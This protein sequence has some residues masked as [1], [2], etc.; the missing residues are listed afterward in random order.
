[1]RRTRSAW[2]PAL[3]L[4]CCGCGCDLKCVD[5]MIEDGRTSE[6]EA[7]AREILSQ[8]EQRGDGAGLDAARA[9][10]RIVL[11]RFR[12]GKI[13]DPETLALARRS[14]ELWDAE[15]PADDPDRCDSLDQLG[16]LLNFAGD[17][18]RAIELHRRA[19]GLRERAFGPESLEVSWTLNYLAPLLWDIGDYVAARPLFER[20][21]AIRRAHGSGVDGVLNNLAGLAFEMGDYPTAR[22]LYEETLALRLARRPVHPLVPS[23][24]TNLG[25]V[26]HRLGELDEAARLALE[27]RDALEAEPL[28]DDSLAVTLGL[29]GDIELSRGR[30]AQAADYYRRTR[31]ELQA[32]VGE[33]H[34]HL[35]QPTLGLAEALRRLGKPDEA[36]EQVQRAMAIAAERLDPD[37]PLVAASAG[38]LARVLLDLGDIDAA[39]E[40]AL[41]A[42]SASRRHLR[43]TARVLAERQGLR[44]AATRVSGLDLALSLAVGGPKPAG[45]ESVLDAVIHSR[46]LVLDEMASRK[47]A[48]ARGAEDELARQLES[49]AAAR[50]RLA[51]LMVRGVSGDEP[52]RA[53][54]VEAARAEFER[55][56]QQLARSSEPY[57]RMLESGRV[58]L[59]DVRDALPR[60]GALVAIA[61]YRR[62]LAGEST[63]PV[64]SYAALVLRGGRAP[65]AVD[66][67]RADEIDTLIDG[68]RDEVALRSESAGGGLEAAEQAYRRVAGKVRERIWDPVAAAL[69][70]ADPVY[71][72]PDGALST[73]NL[74]TLPVG[75]RKYLV[76]SGP[77][78]HLLSAERDL[79][80]LRAERSVGHGLL[81][82]GNP[83]F[84]PREGA[85][86]A[87]G[88]VRAAC[89][90][91]GAEQFG[92]LPESEIEIDE[93]GKTWSRPG[94]PV[95]RVTGA[96]ATE[97]RFKADAPGKRVVHLAT[98]GFFLGS[99]CEPAPPGTRSTGLAG[100]DGADA[101][102]GISP[103]A[104]SGLVFAGANQ[105]AEA[106]ADQD[107]GVLTAEEITALDLDGVEWVVLSACDTALGEIQAGEGVLGLRR[108]F[109]LAG[110]RTLIMSL[111][112]VDDT[113]TRQW[114][115]RL[116]RAR[117]GGAS[118]I[119]AVRGA[120][121]SMLEAR[122]AA[123]ESTH[124]FF[125]GAFVATGGWT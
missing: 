35:V 47:H 104:L 6:A 30:P 124:P 46:A 109:R 55:A 42:E 25:F 62:H 9:L 103:L 87:A 71:V 4:F 112:S 43:I 74:S 115:A 110:A 11:A 34:P 80:A 113:A 89:G 73:V 16:V 63:E 76:E 31:A 118:T 7:R 88:T 117:L 97:A 54:Q 38:R 69:D 10:D 64:P 99:R 90:T 94:E 39:L 101:Q 77:R 32:I 122:R 49:L 68:W 72:V 102:A 70:G 52:R 59:A 41:E 67:G 44:Y 13:E 92:P 86:T 51:N 85:S 2:L 121:R 20:A 27:A 79:V 5:R 37:H 98:H 65:V 40:A 29:L 3:L 58:G 91:L 95:E 45:S 93:I 83:D 82:M 57:R 114:M 60:G 48:V 53:A 15:A 26:L 123:A 23:T 100:A 8:V 111:W 107:D 125:W 75:S 96:A 12:G 119:D 61:R 105:R 56:E 50:R 66:L 28:G 120:S 116:Y 106:A 14:L 84:G 18:D 81:A 78:I 108:A 36:R 17:Y 19:L 24:K 1:V 21:L 22:R 33:D